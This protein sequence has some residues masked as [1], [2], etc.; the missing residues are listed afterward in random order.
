[1]EGLMT[2]AKTYVIDPARLTALLPWST[3]L[4]LDPRPSGSYLHSGS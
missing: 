3:A 1:M 2:R 4:A